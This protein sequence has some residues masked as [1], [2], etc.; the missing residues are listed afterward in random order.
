MFSKKLTAGSLIITTPDPPA[1]PLP[2]PVAPSS[3]PPPPPVLAVPA[4]AVELTGLA[5]AA[6]PPAPPA[7]IPAFSNLPQLPP[8]P[9]LVTDEP[10]IEEATP[11]PPSQPCSGGVLVVQAKVLYLLHLLL[12]LHHHLG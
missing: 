2:P 11:S 1:P 7:P 4:L 8:P 12:H 5:P 9:A 3:P 10:V 6:P